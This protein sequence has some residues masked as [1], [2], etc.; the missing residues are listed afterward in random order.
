MNTTQLRQ[1]IASQ[2][3]NLSLERLTIVSELLD[4]LEAVEPVQ[5]STVRKLEPIRRGKTAKAILE[6]TKTWRGDD[7]EKCLKLVYDARSQAK[8]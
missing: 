4:S 2:L 8:F 7:L 5:S 1:K 6:S 3:N